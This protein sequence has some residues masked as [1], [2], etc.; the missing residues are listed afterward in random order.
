MSDDEHADDAGS[1]EDVATTDLPPDEERGVPA[2]GDADEDGEAAGDLF[3]EVD[4]E[5]DPADASAWETLTEGEVDSAD[6]EDVD[7]TVRVISDRT[8][9]GCRFFADPPALEC[10]HPGTEIRRVVDSERF[11]VVDCPMVVEDIDVADTSR[12]EVEAHVERDDVDFGR[13]ASGGD[14]APATDTD[15]GG[16]GAGDTDGTG[17]GLVGLRDET[18]DDRDATAGVTDRGTASADDPNGDESNPAHD[19]PRAVDE[20]ATGD[21]PVTPSDAEARAVDDATAGAADETSASSD[22][23]S[24]DADAESTTATSDDG[25]PDAAAA[26]AGGR[27][28]VASDDLTRGDADESTAGATAVD[29]D[30]T[31][32]SI[33][34]DETDG[35]VDATDAPEDDD[36]IADDSTPDTSGDDADIEDDDSGTSTT[37]GDSISP[38]EITWGD[39]DG[40]DDE[41]DDVDGNDPA[42]EWANDDD[43]A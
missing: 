22:G 26:S 24:E 23:S 43:G 41:G 36:G 3:E 14:A 15:D 42:I 31:V 32:A 29:A 1:P 18:D 16:D 12:D 35:P 40:E 6:S 19:E 7:G 17:D 11:E 34:A 21:E 33:G 27:E 8:C 38:D 9:H 25:G 37:G 28:S 4:V 13:D 30:G 10:T 2:L 5:G 20:P 39:E